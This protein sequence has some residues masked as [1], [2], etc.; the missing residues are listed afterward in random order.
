MV[1]LTKSRAEGLEIVS[2]Q[3]RKLG[4]LHVPSARRLNDEISPI[5][6]MAHCVCDNKESVVVRL[7]QN[8]CET[9]GE[10]D[11]NIWAK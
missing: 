8:V 4:T 1:L 5:K 3:V 9:P 10:S 11:P 2:D 6:D 7:N